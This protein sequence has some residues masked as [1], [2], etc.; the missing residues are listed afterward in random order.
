[1]SRLTAA[2][3]EVSRPCRWTLIA[4]LASLIAVPDLSGQMAVDRWR[5]VE[6]GTRV[7]VGVAD[8]VPGIPDRMPSSPFHAS[9][10][11][12]QGTVRAIAPDTLYVDLANTVGQV[13]IPRV[14]IQGVEMS[15]GRPSRARSALEAGTTGAVILALFLP[16]FVVDPGSRWFGSSGRATT[17]AAV[18]GFSTGALLGLIR[19]Y[20]RWRIAWIPE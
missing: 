6:I 3:T 9:V 5:M 13:A 15:L 8:R 14:M 2:G 10:Q 7:R 1:M 4:S 11:R 18:I 16:S 19:P 12:L 17:A 20:E